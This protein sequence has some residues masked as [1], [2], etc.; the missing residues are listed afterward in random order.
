MSHTVKS[1]AGDVV[2]VFSD[3]EWLELTDMPKKALTW[4]NS[5]NAILR[6][7]WHHGPYRDKSGLASRK[8]IN[9]M[10]ALGYST[11]EAGAFNSL[12]HSTVFQPVLHR[13][14]NGKRCYLIQLVALPESWYA[15]LPSTNGHPVIELPPEPAPEP[16]PE[17]EPAGSVVAVTATDPAP[18]V[19]VD[20]EPMELQ[21]A[22]A[23]ATA[24][25]TQVIEIISAGPMVTVTNDS[26]QV[27]ELQAD[28]RQAHARLAQRLEENDK[29]RRELRAVRDEHA[30]TIFERDG[31][32]QRLKATEYNLERALKGDNQRI[33]M[34]EVH[35]EVDRMMRAKPV[36]TKGGPD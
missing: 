23:V 4:T 3:D 24:L 32:R 5:R 17:V 31:L 2:T 25:L 7:L 13:E 10:L 36:T 14:I 19:E 22:S 33:I 9:D 27:A 12:T 28:I 20:E 11:P 35:R 18:V 1:P 34:D 16:E 8:L 26:P 30:A 15:H 6:S 21:V 29:L